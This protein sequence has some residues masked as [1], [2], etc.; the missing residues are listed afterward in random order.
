MRQRLKIFCRA[1][2]ASGP[3]AGQVELNRGGPDPNGE[4]NFALLPSR[5]EGTGLRRR[6]LVGVAPVGDRSVGAPSRRTGAI[7]IGVVLPLRQGPDFRRAAGEGQVVPPDP[8][9]GREHIVVV[10]AGRNR[11]LLAGAA[12]GKEEAYRR[13]AHCDLGTC[14]ANSRC[15]FRQS[16]AG[17]WPDRRQ[18]QRTSRRSRL[19]S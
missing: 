8:V 6:L 9:A 12:A 5:P 17:Q 14:A 19:M 3:A 7:G 15:L 16:A 1:R 10:S 2:I 18:G 4:G 11:H 13:G